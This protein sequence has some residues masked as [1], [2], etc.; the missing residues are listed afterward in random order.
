MTEKD[1]YHNESLSIQNHFD[2][3]IVQIVVEHIVNDIIDYLLVVVQPPQLQKPQE[4]QIMA[5]QSPWKG[6]DNI[7][8]EVGLDVILHNQQ[9]LLDLMWVLALYFKEAKND[10][11]HLNDYYIL[12]DFLMI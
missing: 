4:H 10:V 8:D 3:L 6:G 11:K 12:I 7:C 9:W 2:L 5:D 1:E